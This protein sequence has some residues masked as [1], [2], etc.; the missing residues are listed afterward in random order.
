MRRDKT[1]VQI[2]LI[3][4]VA[5]I[6]LA[7]PA[8]ARQRPMDVAKAASEKRGN[9]ED[10]ATDGSGS[11]PMPELE[12]DSDAGSEP[13]PE[14]VSDS[15]E[16][17]HL[18]NSESEPYFS[19]PE[20][21]LNLESSHQVSPPT[22]PPPASF[23]EGSEPSPY[24]AWWPFEEDSSKH[25]A[26]HQDFVPE[27]S[28]YPSWWPF[29]KDS[30]TYPYV[31]PTSPSGSLHQDA[32]PELPDGSSHQDAAPGLP[33]DSS[34][35]N[36]TPELQDGSSHPESSIGTP[37]MPEEWPTPSL[38]GSVAAQQDEKSESP[39][40]NSLHSDLAPP[41]STFFNDAMKKKLKTYGKFGAAA[42]ITAG[43]IAFI[44]EVQKDTVGNHSPGSYV[45]AL[46]LPLLPTSEPL[47]R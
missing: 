25:D 26:A 44:Y 27:S 8:V 21:P 41:E 6:A 3:F 45:S 19:P 4:S 37:G 13:M 17:R 35:Q 38:G 14:L 47:I 46:F 39:I 20:S 32:A 1:I 15:D 43:V 40:F 30:T 11:E 28:R 9:S 18:A 29:D 16:S 22:P 23:R 42:G 12:S 2:L 33:D 31:T 34:H 7:A 36:A 24:P 10:E 5:N